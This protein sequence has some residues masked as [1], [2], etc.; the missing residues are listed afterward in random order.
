MGQD[1]MPMGVHVMTWLP[2]DEV[3]GV[4]KECVG[5]DHHGEGV[6][7]RRGCE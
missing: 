6:C 2:G 1:P 7:W 5:G 4:G 3:V